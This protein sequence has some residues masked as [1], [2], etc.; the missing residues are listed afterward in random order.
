M[1]K[2]DFTKDEVIKVLEYYADQVYKGYYVHKKDVEDILEILD[3]E[4]VI[5]KSTNS[6]NA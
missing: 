1:T 2:T 5:E 6:H 4:E 3:P